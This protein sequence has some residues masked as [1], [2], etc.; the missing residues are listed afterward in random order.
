MQACLPGGFPVEQN[1]LA[2]DAPGVTRERTVIAENP[3]AG[4]GDGKIVRG[5]GTGD[6]A[7]RLRGADTPRDLGIGNGLA[8]GNLLKR[9]PHPMLEGGAADVE[10]KVE[11]DIGRLDEAD[12][13]RDQSLIVAIGADEARVREPILKIADELVRVV[14]QQDRGDALCA[15]GDQDGAETRSVRRR[16]LISSFLPPA[17]YCEGVMPSMSVDFS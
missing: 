3:V 14:S 17:R 11:A 9:P 16:N 15:R 1:A 13:P 7:Y 4:N 2:F 12:D 8:D 6:R 10:R 5:A